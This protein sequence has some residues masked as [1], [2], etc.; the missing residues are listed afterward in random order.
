MDEP[1]TCA[2]VFEKNVQHVH[3]TPKLTM[4]VSLAGKYKCAACGDCRL[5]EPQ[6][7]VQHLPPDDSEGGGL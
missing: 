6:H 7:Q 2:H 5:G 3:V 1:H 4:T